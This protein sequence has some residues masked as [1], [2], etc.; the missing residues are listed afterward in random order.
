M[1]Q[2]QPS[3]VFLFNNEDPQMQQAYEAARATFR[4]LWRELSWERRRIIPAL[5]LACVKAPFGD[6]LPS[7]QAS[8]NPEVEHMWMSEID[9][10]GEQISG[11]LL[12]AP[13]WVKS[14][15]Q[16]D[17]VR[18]PLAHISDWMYAIGDDVYGGHSVNLMRSRMGRQER[19]QHDDAWGLNFGDPTQIRLTQ[20]VKKTKGL[21]SR[22]FGGAAQESAAESE[23]HPMCL[24]MAP[25]LQKQIAEDRSWLTSKD[26]RG[27]TL[28]HQEALA[29][30]AAVVK[31][32]LDAGADRNAV[33]PQGKTPLQL[34]RILGWESVVA[35][36]Q[37]K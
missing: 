29:G 16:G 24:N 18:V 25:E 1:S 32:L 9:F 14:V 2:S 27:W 20:E 13:N 30:N 6:A 19:K 3:R 12:N 21:L 10:D 17:K 4:Y 37:A 26:E 31:V 22:W 11:E 36:L 33:T 28:L 5:S 8:E 7:G 35:L 15:K 34:A 23:D